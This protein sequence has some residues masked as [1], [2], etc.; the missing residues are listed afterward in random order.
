MD[1]NAQTNVFIYALQN[2]G[3]SYGIIGLMKLVRAK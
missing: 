2:V 3:K 1:A